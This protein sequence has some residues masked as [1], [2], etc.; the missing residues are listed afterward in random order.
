[1]DVKMIVIAIMVSKM[2]KPRSSPDRARSRRRNIVRVIH[3]LRTA[4]HRTYRLSVGIRSVPL[5]IPRDGFPTS[6]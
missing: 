5:E 6:G 2:V 4:L 3:F 1:M